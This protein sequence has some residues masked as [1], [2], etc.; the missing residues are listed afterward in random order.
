MSLAAAELERHGIATVA[1]V[2]LEKVARKV[3]PPRALW[4]PFPHGFP[5][6]A[7]EDPELQRRVILAPATRGPGGGAAGARA[8]RGVS[9]G[10]AATA[11]ESPSYTC[12]LPSK[13]WV[14]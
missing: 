9:Y 10:S 6:G 12:T 3:R 7:P 13:P 14:T 4:V 2:L 8:V 1:I 5:L 11:G